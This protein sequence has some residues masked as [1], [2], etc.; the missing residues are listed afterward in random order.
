MT[1][2]PE[3]RNRLSRAVSAAIGGVVAM[4]TLAAGSLLGYV[5]RQGREPD[6]A[7]DVGERM[8]GPRWYAFRE[9]HVARGR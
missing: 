8:A 6:T 5:H 1:R 2:T 3:F 9:Y 4:T 7:A